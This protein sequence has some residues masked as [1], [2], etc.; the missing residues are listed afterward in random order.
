MQVYIEKAL[1][2]VRAIMEKTQSL[3]DYEL[4]ILLGF[5]LGFFVGGCFWAIAS[6]IA[7]S[8]QMRKERKKLKY[9]PI[10]RKRYNQPL[11]LSLWDDL[12]KKKP[13]VEDKT[14]ST[15]DEV[16][17]KKNIGGRR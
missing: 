16:T 7:S 15:E 2:T 9:Y 11:D 13:A 3:S 8:L 6:Y 10:R 1:A 14:D 4:G 17:Y 12:P 5:L